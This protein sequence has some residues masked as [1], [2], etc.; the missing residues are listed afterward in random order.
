MAFINQEKKKQI[1]AALK[2]ALK[3]KKIKY[4]LS[5][6]NHSTIVCTISAS[7]IDFIGNYNGKATGDDRRRHNGEL[8]NANGCLDVNH[9]WLKDHFTGEAL[10]TLET[11]IECLKT[12]DFFDDS[13]SQA[14]YF[15]CSHYYN[16]KIGKFDKPFTVL[17]AQ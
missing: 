2:L 8:V 11:I 14:D 9:Y 1:A 3:D 5:I 16:V 6:E 4:S 12:P 10:N 7:E 17:E 13:D 15:H